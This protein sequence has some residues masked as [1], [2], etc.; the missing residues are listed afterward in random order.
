[1][2]ILEQIYIRSLVESVVPWSLSRWP[3][4]V[5]Y[6]TESDQEQ[7]LW[8]AIM[9]LRLT[10]CISMNSQGGHILF[11]WPDRHI[12]REAGGMPRGV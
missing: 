7:E 2:G 12:E 9:N 8:S 1:M 3:I 11:S 4:E 6:I 10:S 5:V